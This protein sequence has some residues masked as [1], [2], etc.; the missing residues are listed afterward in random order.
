MWVARPSG[1]LECILC[2]ISLVTFSFQKQIV[3]YFRTAV[4]GDRGERLDRGHPTG[5]EQACRRHRVQHATKHAICAIDIVARQPQWSYARLI[6]AAVVRRY[7]GSLS[8][9]RRP[10]RRCILLEI[11]GVQLLVRQVGRWIS[12]WIIP[13]DSY[14]RQSQLPLMLSHSLALCILMH[15]QS[16]AQG[17]WRSAKL[18]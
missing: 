18:Y 13:C 3:V 17:V 4:S 5:N 1:I 14:F 15:L 16:L 11:T 10:V 6:T 2:T 12:C 9:V 8:F 7:L